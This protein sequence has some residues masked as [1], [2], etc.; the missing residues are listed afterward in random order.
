MKANGRVDSEQKVGSCLKTLR[1]TLSYVANCEP[2][3]D[4][5]KEAVKLVGDSMTIV[6]HWI[7]ENSG[8]KLFQ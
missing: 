7:R 2:D 6:D 4:Q 1:D 3:E 5:K 8:S